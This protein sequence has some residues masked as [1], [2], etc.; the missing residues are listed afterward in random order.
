M[1]RAV[2]FCRLGSV[3]PSPRH[4]AGARFVTGIAH[5]E[6]RRL[7]IASGFAQA[8]ALRAMRGGPTGTQAQHAT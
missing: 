3:P 6:D 7:T 2:S 8:D 1:A 5:A 4:D